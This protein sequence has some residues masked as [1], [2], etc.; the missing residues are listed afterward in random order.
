VSVARVG[1][2]TER[3]AELVA[4][5]AGSVPVVR[6]DS[7]SAAGRG[8]HGEILRRFDRFPA[9]ILVGTQMV[10]KGHDFPEVGLGVVVDADAALRFP[11]FRAEERTFSL[12]AQLAGRTGR[13][14]RGGRVLV[15]TLAPTARPIVDAARH[16]AAGFLTGEL[17]R[18]RALRYPPYASLARVELTGV[19]EGRTEAAA[20][21]LAAAL[22][23]GLP[24][25]V[26]L[27]G[28]AP[29]WR[30]RGRHRRRL[31]LKGEG[32]GE[33]ADAIRDPLEAAARN[34][35]LRGITVAVDLDPQ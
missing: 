32:R 20:A 8:A 4:D 3:I 15:Q 5:A 12:L 10:A 2:G 6:L 1:A 18:R 14:E 11:D 27:L 30:R 24:P 23:P 17:E 21:D 13:G 31:L 33:L 35:A 7:D 29:S 22:A 28:P 34:R 16:D 25:G 26:E 9:A 19:D